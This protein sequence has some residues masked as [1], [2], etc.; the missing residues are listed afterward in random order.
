MKV[1][2]ASV[3]RL[4]QHLVGGPTGR[5]AANCRQCLDAEE[6]GETHLPS[7]LAL[8]WQMPAP[9]PQGAV[10]DGQ[11]NLMMRLFQKKLAVPGASNSPHGQRTDHESSCTQPSSFIQQLTFP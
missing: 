9:S 7:G 2:W 5:I 3:K 1:H 8:T 6:F 11:D 4:Q 10:L